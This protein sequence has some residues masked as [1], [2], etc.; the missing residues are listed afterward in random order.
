MSKRMYQEWE[1]FLVALLISERA[2]GDELL[3]DIEKEIVSLDLPAK[4]LTNDTD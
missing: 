2:F 3:K 1:V 4:E